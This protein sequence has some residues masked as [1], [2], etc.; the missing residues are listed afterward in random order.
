MYPEN[1]IK[2]SK[3]TLSTVISSVEE[4]VCLL[5]GWA[6]FITTNQN[7]SNQQGRDY[8][9]SR[10]IDLGFHIDENWSDSEL[11]NSAFASSI[12]ILKDMDYYG[13]GCRFVQH[14][15]LETK[16]LLTEEEA[17]TRPKYTMFDLFV[18]P[19]VDKIHPKIKTLIGFDP[20]DEPLLTKVFIEK[21]FTMSQYFG[22]VIMLPHVEVLVATKIN[23]VTNRDKE[24]KRIKD[25]ADIYALMWYSDTKFAELKKK[26]IELCGAQK[27]S[28]VLSE[29]T[30]ED[31]LK[32]SN[33]IGIDKTEISRVIGEIK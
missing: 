26:V 4:P 1:E 22:K 29:F 32:V 3:S 6:V 17:K 21:K 16:K 5:G 9:G 8:I 18:D 31:Y 19:I 10:D 2:I 12:K 27:I 28:H 13:L 11:Q 24:G 7:F 20:I 25:I 30:E 23:S 33:V 15:D 14:H